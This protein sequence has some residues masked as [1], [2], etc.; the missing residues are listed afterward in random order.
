MAD[1][2]S[3][4]PTSQPRPRPATRKG[5]WREGRPPCTTSRSRFKQPA[6][7]ISSSPPPA[8]RWGR[9]ERS[10]LL[11][12]GGGGCLSKLAARGASPPPPPPPPPPPHTP[13]GA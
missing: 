7:A 3:A 6:I 4:I 11:G 9:D 10:S 12:V 8:K 13:A 1:S 2:D 5:A